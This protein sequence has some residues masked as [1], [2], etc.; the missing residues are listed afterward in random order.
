MALTAETVDRL[1]SPGRLLRPGE[2]CWRLERAERM[3][4]IIDAADYF[5]TVR[6]AL[7]QARHQV[8]LIAWDFDTRIKLVPDAP[9]DG[10]PRRLGPFLAWLVRRR[11]DLHIHVLKWR[12]SAISG[13]W[14]GMLPLTLLN[15]RGESRLEYRLAADHPLGA[16]HHQKIVV[17]DDALAFCGGI[18]MTADR[19]DTRAHLDQDRRR[20]R[21]GGLRYEPFHDITAAVDGDA[22]R[23]LGDLARGRW[24]SATGVDL[25]VP[26]P[27]P[28]LWPKRLTPLLRRVDVGV[29]RTQPAH[30][31]QDAAHEVEALWLA[32]IAGARRR[33][34]IESQYFAS[35]LIAR[36]LLDRLSDPH[37]PEI[38]VINPTDAH[39]W[40]EQQAMGRARDHILSALRAADT[41]GRFAIYAPMTARGRR[42]Y[43]HAKLLVVDDRILRI[44]SSNINNRSMGLDTECDLAVEPGPTQALTTLRQGLVA[45]HLGCMPEE[46]A[47]LEAQTGSLISSIE[48]LRQGPGRTLRPLD[49]KPVTAADAFVVERELLDPERP[50]WPF[51]SLLHRVDWSWLRHHGQRRPR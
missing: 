3:A 12:L 43:V 32:A 50:R 51:Q 22:A 15:W 45:E 7:V 46:V 49:A 48:Q 27:G 9:R 11:P 40:L 31:G 24:R 17:I 25:P 37:G 18:D 30:D 16:C 6:D 4:V 38:V 33:I 2:T 26:P 10:I 5:A 20:R 19:W 35:R 41:G 14:R 28:D 44:G 42:I 23:S 29:A 34:Y 1:P 13:A 8:L 36:A 21:P 39:D 47:R